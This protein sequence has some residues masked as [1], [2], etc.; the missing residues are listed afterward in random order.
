V[1]ALV[2]VAVEGQVS[3]PGLRGN[4]TVG[5]D[6]RPQMRPGMAGVTVNL[7]IGDRALGWQCDHGEPGVSAEGPSPNRHLALQV[8]AALGNRVR[9]TSGLAQG[10][11]GTVTGKHAFVLI[12]FPA[13]VLA[14]ICP[15]DRLVVEAWGQGLQ[16]LDH[17]R[18]TVRNLGPE[19][20]GALKFESDDGC[21]LTVPVVAS[22]PARVMGAGIGMSSEWANCDVML[23]DA[24]LVDELGL[25]NLRLGDLVVMEEQDHRYGR[26]FRSGWTSVGV[27]AHALGPTPGHG[28]GVVTI[29]TGPAAD[30]GT[31]ADPGANVGDLLGL[32]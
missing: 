2:R 10:A 19:L 9:M 3:H 17:P 16:L 12:D 14:E 28:V 18:V 22:L 11:I 5:F 24:A 30:L 4:F 1:E 20:L 23:H 31:R 32:R 29:L 13:D 26:C 15:G 8:L 21:G 27:V 7:R 25:A 6:D